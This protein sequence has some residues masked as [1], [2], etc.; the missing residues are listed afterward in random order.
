M[1][2]SENT[3]LIA[4]ATCAAGSVAVATIG[5]AISA[6]VIVGIATGALALSAF[7][8]SRALPDSS[9]P[10]PAT[11]PTGKAKIDAG[12]ECLSGL[13]ESLSG[14]TPADFTVTNVAVEGFNGGLLLSWE[15]KT[16]GFGQLSIWSDGTT[17]DMDT[18]AM[19]P[20]FVKSVLAK[21]VDD[22]FARVGRE[23]A[24]EPRR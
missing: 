13:G 19:G 2:L 6:P 24:S 10:P 3:K 7:A 20:A 15:T 14:R 21:V 5:A 17:V 8:L 11:P 22:W 12:D 18:E 4:S 16:A 1:T 9:P 23:R